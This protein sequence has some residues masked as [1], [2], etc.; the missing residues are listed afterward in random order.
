MERMQ[1][2]SDKTFSFGKMEY[3]ARKVVWISGEVGGR[4]VKIR[5]KVVEGKVSWIISWD[6]MKEWGMV[7]DV[8][9]M[10]V[11]LRKLGIHVKCTIDGWGNEAGVA[12]KEKGVRMVGE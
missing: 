8:S 11:E 3:K 1:G 2:V 9:N 6:W 12:T 10:E 5:T 7:I 4:K